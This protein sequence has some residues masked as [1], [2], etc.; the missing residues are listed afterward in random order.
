MAKLTRQFLIGRNF[1]R[2]K[3]HEKK[4]VRVQLHHYRGRNEPNGIRGSV[5][6]VFE[7]DDGK[8]QYLMLDKADV[9]VLAGALLSC[10]ERDR[11]ILDIF[12]EALSRRKKVKPGSPSET[13]IRASA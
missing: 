5:G 4:Q 3:P 1:V 9:L 12:R 7:A 13:W 11:E 10:V 8:C 2:S 6:V